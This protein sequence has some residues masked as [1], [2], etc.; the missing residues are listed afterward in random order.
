MNGEPYL[1]TT[2][3]I[4]GFIDTS[5]SGILL[6]QSYKRPETQF[7][8]DIFEL[9]LNNNVMQKQAENIAYDNVAKSDIIQNKVLPSGMDANIDPNNNTVSKLL[10]EDKSVYKLDRTEISAN[11][12]FP[13][14]L[15]PTIEQNLPTNMATENFTNTATQYECNHLYI[16]FIIIS[17][18]LVLLHC[19]KKD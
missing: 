1:T 19:F 2:D 13:K 18:I 15:L 14:V 6:T 9:T 12:L 4:T 17:V 8:G 7:G 10:A 5:L 11:D 3:G 16:I